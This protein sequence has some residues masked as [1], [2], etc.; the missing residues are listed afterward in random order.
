MEE[1]IDKIN[2]NFKLNFFFKKIKVYLQQIKLIK[3]Q[4][5]KFGT[6]NRFKPENLLKII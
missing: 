2:T 4:S 1:I 5:E 6:N 3:Y